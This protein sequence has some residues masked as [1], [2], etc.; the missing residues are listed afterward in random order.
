VKTVAE[1]AEP[2]SAPVGDMSIK[3]WRLG[4]RARRY[5]YAVAAAVI[6]LAL[7]QA[8]VESGLISRAAVASP[9]EIARAA[10]PLITKGESWGAVGDTIRSWS[11]G[12]GIA[13]VV[14]VPLGLL[15]GAN[16]LLYKL[17]RFS[18]DFLRTIPPVAIVPLALLLYGA[19]NRM[20]LVLIVFGSVW[21]MLL[22]SMYGVHQVDAVARDVARAYRFRLR[23]RIFR[24]VLPSAA[25]FIATGIRIAAT[26][27]LLLAVGAE[28]IGGAPGIG[29]QITLEQQDGD[30]PTMFV[31]VVASA[32]LGLL[33]NLTL[34]NLERRA[35]K[36]HTAQRSA[37]V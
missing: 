21:P 31:Y 20:A 30:I 13:L 28:L 16:D 6:A 1:I 3:P 33:V 4:A 11:E 36:W 24:L 23:D 17:T 37:S 15:T 27:S 29:Y 19:T 18:F 22:Q 8:A 5:G 2:S 35:L 9:V 12:L 10:A 26:M 32:L 25:P 7:W 34:I 14:A